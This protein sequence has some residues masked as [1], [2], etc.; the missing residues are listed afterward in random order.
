MKKDIKDVIIRSHVIELEFYCENVKKKIVQS[1]ENPKIYQGS[2]YDDWHYTAI[3]FQCK[4]CG[5][6]HRVEI[7]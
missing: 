6:E 5:K 2:Y 3:R 4:G 7:D 1:V